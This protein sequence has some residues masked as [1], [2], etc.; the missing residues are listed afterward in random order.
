MGVMEIEL[1]AVVT[2]KGP[3]IDEP[4]SPTASI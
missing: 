3:A 4:F 2:V 1:F